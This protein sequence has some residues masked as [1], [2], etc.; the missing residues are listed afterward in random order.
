MGAR[1]KA[2]R[3]LSAFVGRRRVEITA[4]S[5]ETLEIFMAVV[6]LLVNV[7]VMLKLNSDKAN[8]LC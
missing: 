1:R 5:V 7:R 3:S 2:R 6:L 4:I 8:L